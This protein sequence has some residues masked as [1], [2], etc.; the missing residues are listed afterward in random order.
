MYA[1]RDD[2]I[3]TFGE[4]ELIQ[5]TDRATPP[6]GVINDAVLNRGIADAE[7][8]IDGYLAPRY[9]L[10]LTE[11]PPVLKRWTCDIAYFLLLRDRAG[12]QVVKRYESIVKS[13][14]LVNNGELSLGAAASGEVQ[15]NGGA[16]HTGAQRVFDDE[17]L[18][19]Y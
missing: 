15:S 18:A 5:A 1:T 7:A 3:T 9:A 8:E 16:R 14:R 12:E 11:I 13:L 6:A 2:M 19:D 17:S 4:R 10:P